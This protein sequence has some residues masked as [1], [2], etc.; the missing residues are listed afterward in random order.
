MPKNKKSIPLIVITRSAILIFANSI[1]S[2]KID[3]G[4]GC[5]S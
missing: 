2:E 4:F 5:K 1:T 3:G